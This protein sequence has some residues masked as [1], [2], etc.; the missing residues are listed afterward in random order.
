M[1]KI[2]V[3]TPTYN[4]ANLLENLY[5]SLIKNK[6]NTIKVEWLIMD[7]GSN[8]DTENV[9]KKFNNTN[10]LEIKYFKQQNQGKMSAINNLIQYVSGELIIEC[11]SD[12]YFTDNAF[13]IIREEYEK[14]KNNSNL[15]A[16]CFLK[17][18]TNGN[19]MGK[20]LKEEETTMFDLYFK[21]GEDGEKALVYFANIRKNYKYKLEKNE[22]FVTEA[23]LHHKLDLKYKIKCINKPIMVCEYQEAGYTNNIEKQFIENPNGY[24]DYFK[25]IL[26]RKDLKGIT[27]KKRLYV[28]KHYILFSYL[29]KGK[30]NLE[31]I[32]SFLNKFLVAIL[33][34]PGII[35]SRKQF[36]KHKKI[37]FSAYSLEIGG[38]ENAL[39]NLLNK[40]IEEYNITLVLE[41]VK[42]AFL[43]KLDSKVKIIKYTPSRNKN[44]MLRKIVNMLKLIKFAFIYKN[45]FQFSVSF[46]TYSRPGS[47]C[48]RTASK[49]S[50]LWIHSDYLDLYENNEQ[51]VKEFFNEVKYNCFS[52][53][54]IVSEKAKKSITK[55]LKGIEEKTEVINNII[56]YKKIEKLS[57]EEIDIKK[58]DNIITFL[59]VGRHD[60]SSKKLTRLIDAIEIAKNNGYNFKVLFIGDGEDTKLYKELVKEKELDNIITFLGEKKNPYPYFNICDCIIMTSD[61]EGYPVVFNEAKVLNKPIITT[62]VSDS[63]ID[64]EGKYGIVVEKNAEAVYDAMKKYIEEG[65]SIKETFNCENYN[66]EIIKKIKQCIM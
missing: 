64:I 50:C 20:D 56:D 11:D 22:R 34:F 26:M 57:K 66:K 63:K 7:D 59:N 37:L 46:A 42:G 27:F 10:N 36:R 54:I 61:H 14:N 60:E 40:L 18:D 12:D 9:I 48:A 31:E 53:I 5:N 13:H 25:E 28:I 44:I 16:L 3:L 35:K 32:T 6:D 4:R 51:K 33:Y 17:Y 58:D 21:K 45:K 2:S 30:I 39:V 19:N 43:E 8:D 49:N 38:I 65:Y 47:F 1:L 41:E 15:Y 23:R 24:F 52:K 62:N 29:S 55:V